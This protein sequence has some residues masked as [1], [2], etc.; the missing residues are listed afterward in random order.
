VTIA[1]RL[2]GALLAAGCLL[3]AGL[4]AQAAPLEEVK[5]RGELRVAADP[6]AGQP[7]FA[8]S[9]EAFSGFEADLARA[10]AAQLGVKAVF[11][12]TPWNKLLDEVRQDHV[13]VAINAL[14]IQAC[15]DVR[16]S[17]PYYVASQGLLVK[18]ADTRIY[19]VKDLSGRPVGTTKGSV[20]AAVLDNL[21]KPAKV[22][23]YPDTASPFKALATGQVEAVLLES[24]MV[25]WQ[26]KQQPAMFRLAGLPMLP[27]PYGAAVHDTDASLL[28][29][30]NGALAKLRATGAL[31]KLLTGYG[32]WDSV[33]EAPKA[34]PR[35]VTPKR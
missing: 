12:A 2:I 18:K 28:E 19:G 31:R 21:P 6:S 34:A 13:D 14:E 22:K 32:L 4:P 11:V 3:A 7:Y 27:R 1:Q 10:L 24:A 16:F 17:Q 8:Q 30:L 29:G 9:G 26:A 20:A 25:R 23:A 35:A 15:P 5:R 33:Q